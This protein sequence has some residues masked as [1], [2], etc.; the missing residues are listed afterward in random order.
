MLLLS[1]LAILALSSG[2][3]HSVPPLDS[4]KKNNLLPPA[5]SWKRPLVVI[6]FPCTAY[7]MY[8]VWI[9]KMLQTRFLRLQL[10][11]AASTVVVDGD[12]PKNH[13]TGTLVDETLRKSLAK[14]V[15]RK[16][17]E[18]HLDRLVTVWK[19]PF[20][21][22]HNTT[23]LLDDGYYSIGDGGGG[24]NL[25]IRL[26]QDQATIAVVD[27]KNKRF[28]GFQDLVERRRKEVGIV[29]DLHEKMAWQTWLKD[30]LSKESK[31]QLSLL[32][33]GK[34]TFLYREHVNEEE[35]LVMLSKRGAWTFLRLT[36]PSS[37]FIHEASDRN[38][39]HQR[40]Y[41]EDHG[42][43]LGFLPVRTHNCGRIVRT[44][45]CF[46]IEWESSSV[47]IG[48][49][50]VG[51]TLEIPAVTK[52]LLAAPWPL[53][54]VEEDDQQQSQTTTSSSS[55]VLLMHRPKNGRLV[56]YRHG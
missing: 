54:S 50:T 27:E 15:P 51:R 30:V 28:W 29:E 46:Q 53:F 8:N 14:F 41:L 37:L 40:C 35:L 6:A 5:A 42:A 45:K 47:R 17:C 33:P 24:G 18:E 4:S 20:L 49:N 25:A 7:A 55:D 56:W 36:K 16:R 34:Y 19:G 10:L 43:L 11:A 39:N 31:K 1:V 12:D 21:Q 48:W 44:R 9:R 3:A 13:D 2:E 26:E 52:I 23:T 22:E 38:N 32:T